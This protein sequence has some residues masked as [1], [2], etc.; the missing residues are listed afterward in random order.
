MAFSYHPSNE[1]E[2]LLCCVNLSFAIVVASD[3]KCSFSLKITETV[4]EMTGVLAW[5]VIKGK[6]NGSLSK[7]VLDSMIIGDVTDQWSCIC[8]GVSPK[9]DSIAVA[10]TEGL[11]AL[12]GN[13][14]VGGGIS[15]HTSQT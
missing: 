1:V 5:P 12:L 8:G 7:A 14:A 9:R 2:P 15:L 13:A 4:E 11:L 6:S 10:P 3:E